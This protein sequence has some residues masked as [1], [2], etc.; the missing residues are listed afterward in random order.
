[1]IIHIAQRNRNY[2][3]AAVFLGQCSKSRYECLV[4]FK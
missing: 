4:R 2:M 3:P 1:M